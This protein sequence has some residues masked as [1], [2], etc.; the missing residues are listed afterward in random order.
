[1]SYGSP[2]GLTCDPTAKLKLAV[3]AMLLLHLELLVAQPTGRAQLLT[4][5][6][7]ILVDATVP[8]LGPVTPEVCVGP[9]P[10]AMGV[11]E[12]VLLGHIS[13]TVRDPSK[14]RIASR[15]NMAGTQVGLAQRIGHIFKVGESGAAASGDGARARDSVANASHIRGVQQTLNVLQT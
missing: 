11:V 2:A 9:A 3:T 8:A 14:L 15:E 7:S 13:V 10:C 5:I 1:M 4:G 6:R 12:E